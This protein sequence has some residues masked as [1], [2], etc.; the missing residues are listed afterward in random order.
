MRFGVLGGTFDPIHYGH[1]VIA[2]EALACLRLDKVLFVPAHESPHKTQESHT[3]AEHRLRM[4]QLAIASNPCF[5][6]SEVDLARPA[7][8]YTIDT[9]ALLQR[10]LGPEAEL[11]FLMGMDSLAGLLTWYRPDLLI[12]R[13][14][15]AVA[16][17]P[18]YCV[19]LQA[20]EEAL[21]G[22]TARVDLLQPPELAISSRDLRRRVSEGL[23]IKYQLPD[24]VEEYIR[25]Q[26]LYRNSEPAGLSTCR[27]AQ[28]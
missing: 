18:G 4:V 22:F 15:L 25:E 19:D 8:S 1:M 26:G 6:V 28:H 11:F 9:L 16:V 3:A 14:R 21:P 20:F 23:P 13:A 7:P 10:E 5:E 12:A 2:Q 17:R 27:A 24:S